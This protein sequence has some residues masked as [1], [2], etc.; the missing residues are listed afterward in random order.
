M[1]YRSLVEHL[2]ITLHVTAIDY[3][4]DNFKLLFSDL[5]DQIQH[6]VISRSVEISKVAVSYYK[7]YNL[8]NM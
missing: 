7:T 3:P 8:R 4:F 1:F 5:D 2:D 6:I